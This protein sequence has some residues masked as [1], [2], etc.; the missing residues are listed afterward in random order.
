[1]PRSTFGCAL[2]SLMC[3]VASARAAA[4]PAQGC[5]GAKLNA[6]GK[7]VAAML[8]C[9]A[10]AARHGGWGVVNV[11]CVANARANLR[12][13]FARLERRGGCATTRDARAIARMLDSSAGAFVSALRPITT[14]NRCVAKKLRATAN[15]AKAKLLCYGKA[16]R[17][18]SSVDTGCLTNAET[19]FTAGFAAAEHSSLC[20]TTQDAY[21]VET[22]VDDFVGKVVAALPSDTTATTSTTST[23]TSTSTA[24]NPTCA[25]Y[26][27]SCRFSV[28]CCA[29]YVCEDFLG[30]SHEASCQT[31]IDDFDPSSSVIVTGCTKAADCCTAGS[32]CVIGCPI[33]YG[34]F[35][36]PSDACI[37]PGYPCCAAAGDV[38]CSG[39]ACPMEGNEA[40]FCPNP[41]P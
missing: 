40:G 39:D 27:E 3:V 9:H 13:R 38:C 36:M 30:L 26:G 10:N 24:T 37:P 2:V 11:A 18:G 41:P 1:M 34:G 32:K 7:V 25:E 23:T 33:P 12:S 19:Q 31:C 16:T 29:P 5:A 4:T 17:G 20:V 6:T 8:G 35:C 28:T 14:A 22:V 15:K 21:D